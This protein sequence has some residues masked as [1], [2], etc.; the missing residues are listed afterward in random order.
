MTFGYVF[1]LLYTIFG[2][3][4]FLL[5][6]IILAFFVPFL[7]ALVMPNKKWLATWAVFLVMIIAYIYNDYRHTPINARGA[8]E[9]V[10]IIL[11]SVLCFGCTV[12]VVTRGVALYLQAVGWRYVSATFVAML[13]CAFGFSTLYGVGVIWNRWANR[14]PSSSCNYESIT[15]NISKW[16]IKLATTSILSFSVDTEIGQGITA[17]SKKYYTFSGG[18]QKRE[19]CDAFHGGL[20]LI[21]ARTLHLS[22]EY[23][24]EQSAKTELACLQNSEYWPR[25][26]CEMSAQGKVAST[27]LSHGY[28]TKALSYPLRL[29]LSTADQFEPSLVGVEIKDFDDFSARKHN[30]TLVSNMMGWLHQPDKDRY[31]YEVVKT[32]VRA[33]DGRPIVIACN[34]K[35]PIK[36]CMTNYVINQG[37]RIQYVMELP[38]EDVEEEF[39]KIHGKVHALLTLA[40]QGVLQNGERK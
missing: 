22:F 18:G 25:D 24:N 21:N 28:A 3:D 9:W 37:V 8:G 14:N 19:Y 27:F 16:P 38:M 2:S 4:S 5:M 30:Y 29:S 35:N 7:I 23:W 10:G 36:Y 1:N 32:G 11:Y 31:W 15:V 20:N 13:I 6:P 12:G 26:L 34:G 17:P 33:F 39:L 40:S